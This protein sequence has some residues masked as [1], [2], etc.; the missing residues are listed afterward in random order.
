MLHFWGILA[1]V[2]HRAKQEWKL[3]T[4]APLKTFLP[5][6]KEKGAIGKIKKVTSIIHN[7]VEAHPHSKIW[8]CRCHPYP[9]ICKN[10]VL[11]KILLEKDLPISA[12]AFSTVSGLAILRSTKWPGLIFFNRTF[13]SCHFIVLA[14]YLLMCSM[15]WSMVPS[16]V[17]FVI[18]ESVSSSAEAVVL[19]DPILA[20]SGVIASSPNR[21]LKGVKP[22]DLETS[23]LLGMAMDLIY[24]RTH[25]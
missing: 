20:S 22:V 3:Q 11:T 1:R 7:I 15:A 21:S 24:S 19:I 13:L 12:V 18:W 2:L 4:I 16:M 25:G 23:V 9:S 5:S 6:W 8:V 14:W 17:S 10:R